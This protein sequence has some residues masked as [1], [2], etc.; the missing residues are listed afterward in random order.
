MTRLDEIRRLIREL[1]AAEKAQLL[2]WVVQDLD[3]AFPGVEHSPGVL[4]GEARVVRTRI[5]V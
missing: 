2:R 5:P 1:S 4:G 3:G